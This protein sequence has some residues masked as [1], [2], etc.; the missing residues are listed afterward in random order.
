MLVKDLFKLPETVKKNDFVTA[1][2]GAMPIAVATSRA[3]A[4]A[5]KYSAT[6]P[7]VTVSPGSCCR[8]AV[9]ARTSTR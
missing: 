2:S 3:F 7:W 6:R 9:G 5:T 4:P 8:G 1:V